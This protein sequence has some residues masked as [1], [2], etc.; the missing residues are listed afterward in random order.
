MW[1]SDDYTTKYH[2]CEKH[3]ELGLHIEI[4]I[5]I[6]SDSSSK[7]PAEPVSR[8]MKPAL[9]SALWEV[10]PLGNFAYRLLIDHDSR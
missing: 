7:M 3:V 1:Q 4:S 6:A 2:K 9:N 5:D 10:L 8:F